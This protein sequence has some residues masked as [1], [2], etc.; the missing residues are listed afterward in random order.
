MDETDRAEATEQLICGY[1]KKGTGIAKVAEQL[2]FAGI[3][4]AEQRLQ[5]S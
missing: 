2:T 3:R 5:N 4:L 1:R